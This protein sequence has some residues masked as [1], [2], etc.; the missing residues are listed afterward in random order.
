M[1]IKL[2]I[3]KWYIHRSWNY[4]QIVESSLFL[5][6][7]QPRKLN[8]LPKIDSIIGYWPF[9][10]SHSQFRSRKYK[11]FMQKDKPNFGRSEISMRC[12]LVKE[13]D[14][15]IEA[16]IQIALSQLS[17]CEAYCCEY[18]NRPLFHPIQQS[19]DISCGRGWITVMVQNLHRDHFSLFARYKAS[20]D[21][22]QP[23][24]KGLNINYASF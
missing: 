23:Y 8:N 3:R 24:Y 22:L 19:L 13:C 2:I 11:L 6:E 14:L 12:E 4:L 15:W 10:L 5:L 20:Q 21:S 7:I 1:V 16:A 18:L 9:L 17:F